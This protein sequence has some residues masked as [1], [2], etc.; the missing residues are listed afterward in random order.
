MPSCTSQLIGLPP[1]SRI[2][3]KFK[4]HVA[5]V[6]PALGSKSDRRRDRYWFP[7]GRCGPR[8]RKLRLDRRFWDRA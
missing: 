2:G 6:Q 3:L 5:P 7:S 4:R 8:G 1:G